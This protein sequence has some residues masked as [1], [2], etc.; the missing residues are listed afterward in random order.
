MHAHA[1]IIIEQRN[2]SEISGDQFNIIVATDAIEHR[3]TQLNQVSSWIS[4]ILPGKLWLYVIYFMVM[5][6]AKN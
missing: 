6:K 1:Q 5:Y 3:K 4:E 2:E